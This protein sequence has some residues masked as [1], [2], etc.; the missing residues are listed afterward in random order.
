MRKEQT[1]SAAK[2]DDINIDYEVEGDS[3]LLVL[4]ICLLTA[5]FVHQ[6]DGIGNVQALEQER[7]LVQIK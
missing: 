5:V 1:T 6:V 4:F 7:E 3:P 2:V